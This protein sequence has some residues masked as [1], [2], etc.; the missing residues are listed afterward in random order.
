MIRCDKPAGRFRV[1][2]TVMHATEAH[3]QQIM[4]HHDVLMP[5]PSDGSMRLVEAAPVAMT[6]KPFEGEL[7]QHEV[8]W[9]QGLPGKEYPAYYHFKVEPLP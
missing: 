1:T 2:L 6:E 5:N 9:V 3:H 7:C 8:Q 4:G